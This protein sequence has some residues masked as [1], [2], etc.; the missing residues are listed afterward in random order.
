MWGETLGKPPGHVFDVS[1]RRLDRAADDLADALLFRDEHALTGPVEGDSP[2]AE[3]FAARGERDASGRSLREFD[4]RTRLFRLSCSYLIK[5]ESYAALPVE[6]RTRVAQHIEAVLDLDEPS[7]GYA[8]L[9][10]EER[11]ALRGLLGA[12]TNSAGR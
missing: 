3:E 10:D 8:N 9:T 6:I 4:L 7:S 5:S 2:F 11:T 1:T 12:H